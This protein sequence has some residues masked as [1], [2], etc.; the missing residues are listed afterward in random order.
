VI[1]PVLD[2]GFQP[3]A[4][5]LGGKTH[6]LALGSPAIDFQFACARTSSNLSGASFNQSVI[7]P[8]IRATWKF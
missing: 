8:V 4:D 6:Y 7:G 5:W 1:R 2:L 3:P